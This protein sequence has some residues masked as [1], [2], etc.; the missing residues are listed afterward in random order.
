MTTLRY[1]YFPGCQLNT[2]LP[3]YDL[4]VRTIMAQFDVTLYDREMNCCGYPVR[5]QDLTASVLAA[6]R[7]LAVAAREGLALMTPCQCC[8]GNLKHA[9]YWL[10]QKPELRRDVNAI[11]KNEG[12]RW[13]AGVRV[14]HLLSVLADEIGRSSIH[15]RITQPLSGIRIAAHYGCHALRPGHVVQFDNPLAPSLFEKLVEA[16]GAKAVDWPLRLEC[17][18]H[19]QWGK[20]DRLALALMVRKIKDAQL[21]GAQL[22]TTACTYCQIQFD[23]VR[24]DQRRENGAG[25]DLPAVLYTQLLG[26]AMGLP[27]E[28]LGVAAN[29]I[30]PCW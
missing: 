11:L 17:C 10:R 25:A 22:L 20:N 7:N 23:A 27:D 29:R 26:R 1:L 4:S 16:T 21:A 2:R 9:D 3:Q 8:Y 28:R 15:D 18:G 14:H 13:N 24:A 30:Q 12:L 6:A 5:H 19:P